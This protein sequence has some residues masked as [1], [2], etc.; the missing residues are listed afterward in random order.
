MCV[1]QPCALQDYNY[2]SLIYYIHCTSNPCE[3]QLH[4]FLNLFH[5]QSHHHNPYT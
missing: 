3:N 2:P 4:A 1:F 5:L